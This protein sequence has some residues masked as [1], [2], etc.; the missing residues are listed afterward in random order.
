MGFY[1]FHFF[2]WWSIKFPQQNINQSKT[3]IGVKAML[4]SQNTGTWTKCATACGQTIFQFSNEERKKH[5]PSNN[6]ALTL[7]K[8]LKCSEQT[9]CRCGTISYLWSFKY[10]RLLSLTPAVGDW[11]VRACRWALAM[12]LYRPAQAEKQGEGALNSHL[13]TFTLT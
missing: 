2:F 10:F 4:G 7:W 6:K 12:A 13:L 11:R 5:R 3:W 9:V 8:E 1:H